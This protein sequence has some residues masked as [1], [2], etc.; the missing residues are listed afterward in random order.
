[1]PSGRNA[2]A[3]P[4]PISESEAMST[5]TFPPR[6]PSAPSTPVSPRGHGRSQ[7]A[8][9]SS[10]GFELPSVSAIAMRGLRLDTNDVGQQANGTPHIDLRSPINE[11]ENEEARVIPAQSV[12]GETPRSSVDFYNMSNSTTETLLSEYDP[13][14]TSRLLRPLHGRRHSLMPVGPKASETLMMG[15]AHVMGTFVLDGSL[16]QTSAFED[17]KRKGVVGT[18]SGGGVVGVET[19]KTDGGF[20]SGFSWGFGGLLG[21]GRMSSIA[22]MKTIAS[23]S[24]RRPFIDLLLTIDRLETHTDTLHTTI[25]PIC[26]PEIVSRRE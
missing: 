18:H 24:A 16:I 22:E 26:R 9:S 2:Q 13:R 23:T 21:G 25:N 19:S 14:G 8:V 6:K 11:T 12:G 17:V 7:S 3:P 1:M 5:F 15:Y 10:R 4:T 20:L